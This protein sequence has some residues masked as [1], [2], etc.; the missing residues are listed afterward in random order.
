MINQNHQREEYSTQNMLMFSSFVREHIPQ[1]PTTLEPRPRLDSEAVF[2]FQ[3]NATLH[4]CFDRKTILI[5]EISVSCIS[6]NPLRNK[7]GAL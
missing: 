3:P 1:F 7:G 6:A 5:H 4:V 2:S